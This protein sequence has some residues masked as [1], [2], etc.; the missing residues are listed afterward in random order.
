[1][2]I[3]FSVCR[4]NKDWI[5]SLQNGKTWRFDTLREAMGAAYLVEANRKAA[6]PEAASGDN[7]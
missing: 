2:T 6:H 3:K 4:N 7:I 5:V 1:M